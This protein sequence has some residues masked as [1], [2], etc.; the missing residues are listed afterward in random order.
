MNQGVSFK[1]FDVMNRAITSAHLYQPNFLAK[2]K[3]SFKLTHMGVL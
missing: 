1:L 2:H 3:Q